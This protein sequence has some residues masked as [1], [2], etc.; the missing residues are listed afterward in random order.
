MKYSFNELWGRLPK[1][2]RDLMKSSIQDPVWHPEG[3][4]EVHTRRVFEYA[5]THFP[6]NKDLL[7]VAIFHDLGKP[8]TQTIKA[9]DKSFKGDVLS[10]EWK[11]QKISNLYHELKADKY[12][13]EYFHLFSD[14]STD[15]NKFKEICANHLKAHNYV[16]GGIRKFNKLNNFEN[17][18]YYKDLL[19]FEECDSNGKT[20]IDKSSFYI[21]LH[22]FGF[23]NI[24]WSFIKA[25]DNQLR[26]KYKL[27]E[28][29]SKIYFTDY[30]IKED[31][32]KNL[33]KKYINDDILITNIENII[34][35]IIYEMKK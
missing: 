19:Q 20:N 8:E 27:L 29:I 5:Q 31:D 25:F 14:F 10:L 3:N 30:I 24:N 34:L 2:H 15:I 21:K 23:F 18:K 32:I 1:Q 12:L 22:D 35:E 9:R 16:N 11:D 33:S 13:D 17:L 6:E 28:L 4:C 26:L 7:L